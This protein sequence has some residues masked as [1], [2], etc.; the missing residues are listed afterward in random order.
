[1]LLPVREYQEVGVHD[2]IDN[3]FDGYRRHL[4]EFTPVTATAEGDHRRDAD[5]DDWPP[6]AADE[7]LRDLGRLRAALNAIEDFLDE[8]DEG[9]R[10]MLANALDAQRFTFDGLRSHERDPTFWLDLA[11]GGVYELI[12]RDD[13]DPGPRRLAAASRAAQVPR[14]LDQARATLDGITAPHREVALLRAPSAAALFR[15]QLGN[16]APEAA[17]AGEAAAVA[18]EGFAAWLDEHRDDPA[19]DW[20]LGEKRWSEAFRL[21]IGGRMPAA[22][23]WERAWAEL[24]TLQAMAEETAFVVLEGHRGGRAGPELV[25]AALEMAAADHPTREGLVPEAAASLGEIVA[26]IRE[27]GLFPLPEPDMLRVEKLP[28]FRRG[29]VDACLIP[30]PSLE[31]TAAHTFYLSP[32]PADW[33]DTRTTSF[34]REYNR[35]ALRLLGIHEAYPGHYVQYAHARAHPRLLRRALI[36]HAFLEGW[37]VYVEHEIVSAG[38]GDAV[39]GLTS[40]KLALRVVTNALLDQGLHVHGWDDDTALE[41]MIGRTYQEPAEASGKLLRGKVTAGQLSTYFVGGQEMAN[42][43]DE[44]ERLCGPGFSPAEFHEEVLAHGTPPFAVLR[45]A[46]LE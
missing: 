42:L 11:T 37:A 9:D 30:A 43:R 36:N 32:I 13:L 14:L 27:T 34:L 31:P 20:R 1:M 24:D 3:T 6:G 10:L 35:S 16:F 25:R 39:L 44:V 41:L 15:D 45:R 29:I 7:R 33:D 23:I 17:E 18:C 22:K 28:G 46:L 26:F 38:F 8:E 2:V 4:L 40:A 21:M 5:L 19:P 12:R